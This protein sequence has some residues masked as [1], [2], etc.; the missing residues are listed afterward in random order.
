MTAE[1][2]VVERALPLVALIG[3]VAPHRVARSA[4]EQGGTC[5]GRGGAVAARAADSMPGTA[6]DLT[7]C[8]LTGALTGGD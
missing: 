3:A 4:R 1:S 6:L 5:A 8:R 2:T 7:A